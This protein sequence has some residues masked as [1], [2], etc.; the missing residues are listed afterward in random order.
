MEREA[1]CMI[2]FDRQTGLGKML[3]EPAEI[4]LRGPVRARI[5]RD[6]IT[7]FAVAGEDLLITTAMGPL[8]AGLGAQAAALWVKA[9]AKPVPTLAE[10]LGIKADTAVLVIGPLTDSALIAVLSAVPAAT[11]PQ[12]LI[13]ELP[14][15]AA[16]D[17]AL[18]GCTAHPGAAFWGITRK[19][20]SAFTEADLRAKMRA[21]GYVD[22]KSCTVSDAFTA[23]RYGLR[24][25]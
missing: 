16:F 23:T 7:G 13:A 3:L 11:L 20:K 25:T 18:A 1:N 10:K 14:D 5:S 4:I 17:A 8:R 21:A 9:L 24:R 2:S 19:G 6:L 15:Q 12:L 22:T